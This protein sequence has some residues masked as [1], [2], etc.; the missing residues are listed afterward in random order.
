MTGPC[1][2]LTSEAC[3]DQL[4][5]RFRH[6]RLYASELASLDNLRNVLLAHEQIQQVPKQAVLE[7]P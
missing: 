6:N 7:I 1:R 5:Y 3:F 4:E 2:I